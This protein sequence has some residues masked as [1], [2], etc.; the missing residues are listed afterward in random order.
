[1][2]NVIVVIIYIFSCEE[3]R[4][5]YIWNLSLRK[6]KEFKQVEQMWKDGRI[7]MFAEVDYSE[8]TTA[9]MWI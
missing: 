7:D 4:R 5:F 6:G 9:Y 3:K 8:C 2:A 1:M